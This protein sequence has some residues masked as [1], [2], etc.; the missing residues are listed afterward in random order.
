MSGRLSE[1]FPDLNLKDF[2]LLCFIA[3]LGEIPD[4]GVL[5][6]LT[7]ISAHRKSEILSG[8]ERLKSCRYLYGNGVSPEY[9]FHAVEVMMECGSQWESD[10]S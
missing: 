3:W 6:A 9:F 7:G 5:K 4:P 2:K 8:I 1:Y 10:F